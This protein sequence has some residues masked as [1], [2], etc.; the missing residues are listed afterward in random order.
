MSEAA[1]LPNGFESLLPFVEFWGVDTAAERAH[2][3]DTSTESQRVDFYNAML[4]LVPTALAHL[5]AKTFAQFDEREQ[6]LMKLLLSFAHVSLAVELQRDQ[7]P[8]HATNRSYMPITRA[9]ADEPSL[10][11]RG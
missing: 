9:P 7:E 6:R 3:R 2:C 1:E 5:D 10:K 8:A 4:D 11:L